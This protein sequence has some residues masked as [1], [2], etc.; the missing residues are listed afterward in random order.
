[1]REGK[2]VFRCFYEKEAGE[3]DIVLGIFLENKAPFPK[4]GFKLHSGV[5]L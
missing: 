1:M 4:P 3:T 2:C 5:S